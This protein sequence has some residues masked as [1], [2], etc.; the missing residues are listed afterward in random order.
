ME[1]Q[2]EHDTAEDFGQAVAAAVI[3]QHTA[4]PKTGKPQPNEHT[5]LAGFVLSR[6]GHLDTSQTGLA[7]AKPSSYH[8][9]ATV[10]M[11]RDA[12]TAVSVGTGT[13][14]LGAS[15]RSHDGDVIN[16]SHAEVCYFCQLM[17]EPAFAF[18]LS[19][20]QN[21]LISLQAGHCPQGSVTLDLQRA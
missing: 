7:K 13:K 16:D 21:D 8:A 11:P 15:K 9:G 20:Q 10:C 2:T 6:S 3:R 18:S 5:V 12:L 14:C 1:E 17:Q 4:L 19:M